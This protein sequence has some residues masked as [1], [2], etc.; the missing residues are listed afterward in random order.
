MRITTCTGGVSEQLP[1][2]ERQNTKFLRTVGVQQPTLHFITAT[3][4]QQLNNPNALSQIRSHVSKESH[5]RRRRA[6]AE[7]L[8]LYQTGSITVKQQLQARSSDGGIPL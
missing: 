2:Q 8:A 1:E 7:K 6:L 3:R 4:P 5:A